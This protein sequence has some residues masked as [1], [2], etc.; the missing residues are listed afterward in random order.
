MAYHVDSTK[1]DLKPKKNF[2][3]KFVKNIDDGIKYA[4][5]YPLSGVTFDGKD[6]ALGE[7]KFEKMGKCNVHS[8]PECINKDRHIYVRN[9]PTGMMPPFNSSFYTLTN[10]NLQGLTEGRGIIPGIY[11]DMYDINPVELA[12]GAIGTGHLGNRMCKKLRL[13]V[14]YKIYD[15]KNE[16]KTWK[17][18]T[19]CSSSYP[20]ET[21]HEKINRQILENNSLIE[22]FPH[23]SNK[24]LLILV[25]FFL[26]LKMYRH[27]RKM[28][29]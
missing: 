9:I 16:N 6:I 27:L 20:I 3:K 4:V 12:R 18:E 21:T 22:N 14:G 26:L 29:Q 28:F 11:E 17:W 19:Q 7:N 15:S 5:N 24:S 25:L 2:S 8:H 23:R 10:C 1:L 13:P